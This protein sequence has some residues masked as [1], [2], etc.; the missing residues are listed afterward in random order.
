[1]PVTKQESLWILRAQS[2]DRD[3]LDAI[4]K[5]VQAP[6]HRYLTSMLRDPVDADDAL[7]EVF[8]RI[9]RKLRWLRNPDL[10]RAWCYRI[11]SREALRR[12]QSRSRR[13]EEPWNE[14]QQATMPAPAAGDDFDAGELAALEPYLA[15]VS[16]A[17]RE[18]LVL[19]Y[20]HGL[21][22]DDVANILGL[23]PGTVRSRLAYGLAALRSQPQLFAAEKSRVTE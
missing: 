22:L 23:A 4:L 1:M 5:W 11:A 21:V 2:G 7:Q 10:F 17:S 18:V 16:P 3:A 8:M 9:Y 15:R 13:R 12:L 20:G 19:H 14:A 6:L